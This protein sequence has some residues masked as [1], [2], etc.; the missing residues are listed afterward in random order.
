MYVFIAVIKLDNFVHCTWNHEKPDLTQRT[1]MWTCWKAGATPIKSM[2][3][4]VG[5]QMRALGHVPTSFVVVQAEED[6]SDWI[7][8]FVQ[9]LM[10]ITGAA[11]MVQQVNN[12][13][14]TQASTVY[15]IQM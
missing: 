13:C 14:P 8:E 10:G 9:Q 1:E 5:A 6:S 2:G 11:R 7:A 15:I 3:L 4:D 12:D